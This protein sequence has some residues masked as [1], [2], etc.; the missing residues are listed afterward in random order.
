MIRWLAGVVCLWLAGIAVTITPAIAHE[1]RPAYLQLQQTAEDQWAVSWKQPVL[2]GMRLKISPAFAG[3]DGKP[4][5]WTPQSR[6]NLA[7]STL[8]RGILRCTL[9]GITIIGLDRTLTDVIVETKP[10]GE[11]TAT[12]LLRPDAITLDL[13]RPVASPARA[14]FVLGIDHI[15]MGWDHLLFVIGLVLLIGMQWR[16]LGVITAFTAAHSLTLGLAALGFVG[17]PSRPV[18]ILIAAS[19][20]LLGVEVVRHRAGRS[21]LIQQRPFLV[22]GTVGLIHGLGFA[23]AL[24]EIGLPEGTELLA[25][26]MF[27]LGVEAGQ[28]AVIGFLLA[29]L[30]M[31]RKLATTRAAH[32]EIF[33]AYALGTIGTYWMLERIGQYF[34]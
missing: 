19:I 23:G 18:E 14:Y 27:N 1:V 29:L 4:C 9:T 16:L 26:L 5:R 25:L 32:V 8:E 2:E 6:E 28:L 13:S 11:E 7:A 21:S 15:V 17:V 20:V 3:Q 30:F 10:L 34:A 12:A 31:L 22:A 33:A 24:R